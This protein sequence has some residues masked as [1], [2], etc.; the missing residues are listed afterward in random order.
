ML[1]STEQKREFFFLVLNFG[2]TKDNVVCQVG[3]WWKKNCFTTG[4][5]RCQVVFLPVKTCQRETVV[6]NKGKKQKTSGNS[7]VQKSKVCL[8]SCCVQFF[9]I[10]ENRRFKAQREKKSLNYVFRLPD[11]Q[12]ASFLYIC[13]KFTTKDFFRPFE[14]TNLWTK[15]HSSFGVGVAIHPCFFKLVW[16]KKEFGVVLN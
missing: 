13:F 12:H 16:T 6:K 3:Q 2:V 14:S 9:E 4:I 5:L 15:V 1:W 8:F 11:K 10:V 7:K